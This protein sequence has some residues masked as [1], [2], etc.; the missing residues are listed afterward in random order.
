[1]P[2]LETIGYAIIGGV[3]PAFIW[4]YFLLKEDAKHP[5]P[6][7]LIAIAF[8]A[9]MIGVPFVIPF[10]E[11]ARAHFVALGFGATSLPVLTSW[12]AIE[13][14]VKYLLAAAFILW[15]SAVDEAPDYVIYMF[16]VALGFA[17]AENALFLYAP[18]SAGQ[19]LLGIETDNLRFVG[20]TLLHVFASSAIGFALAFSWRKSPLARVVYAAAGLILAVAL[21][22]AF[23]TLIIWKGGST[24]LV[25]FFLVW[26]AAV[27]FFA[28][29]EIL[30][31]FQS[32]RIV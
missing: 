20:S 23:N 17:A 26:S 18:L 11:L 12:A 25:A 2:S 29:F 24:A 28:L 6:K 30:K 22:T 10:E 4:L 14:L 15:R 13:E 9:G 16:T 3:L 21:H 27:V 19:Y 1:M 7:R 5:E 31:Y 8:F 32:R